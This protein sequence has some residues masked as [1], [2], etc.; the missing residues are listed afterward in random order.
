MWHPSWGPALFFWSGQFAVVPYRWFDATYIGTEDSGHIPPLLPLYQFFPS[1]FSLSLIFCLQYSTGLY[2]DTVPGCPFQIGHQ[3]KILKLR[4][5]QLF[6]TY[7]PSAAVSFENDWKQRQESSAFFEASKASL[8]MCPSVISIALRVSR[9]D[10]NVSTDV[11][12]AWHGAALLRRWWWK[13]SEI[14]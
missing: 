10:R 9:R 3:R 12:F 13:V 2:S 1:S 6:P 4:F 5:S 14:F 8:C 11:W 7:Y